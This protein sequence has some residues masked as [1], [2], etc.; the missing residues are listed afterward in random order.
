MS[1]PKTSRGL[2][3]E[4]VLRIESDSAIPRECEPCLVCGGTTA[5]P[6][7]RTETG[8]TIVVCTQCGLGRMQPAPTLDEIREFYPQQYYGETGAKIFELH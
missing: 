3:N 8:R 4:A 2:Y 6:V 7:F 5:R 1:E